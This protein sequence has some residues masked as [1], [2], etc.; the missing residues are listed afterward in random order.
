MTLLGFQRAPWGDAVS[1]DGIIYSAYKIDLRN[2]NFGKVFDRNI[3]FF[4]TVPAFPDTQKKIR[5]L[6]KH[7]S[8][9]HNHED[10]VRSLTFV[11][12]EITGMEP[13]ELQAYQL[14]GKIESA[15][16][17]L[18]NGP[19][20]DRI[21]SQ[22]IRYSYIERIGTHELIAE[23]LNLSVPTYY[24]YLRK[25]ISRLVFVLINHNPS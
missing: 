14:Q 2:E 18:S 3:E 21:F 5:K 7:Y 1:A 6:L 9:L 11:L 25:A 23:R 10:L 17:H 8:H 4:S 20:E 19:D 16:D 15:L 24:R 12:P 13:I 22:I